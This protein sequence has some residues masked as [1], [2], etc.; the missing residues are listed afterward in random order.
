MS[1]AVSNN[2]SGENA[3]LDYELCVLSIASGTL[4]MSRGFTER[5][6]TDRDPNRTGWLQGRIPYCVQPE[7]VDAYKAML[8]DIRGE[9][10]Q[11]NAVIGLRAKGS[12]D[13]V[14]VRI[15]WKKTYN[16]QGEAID[17]VGVVEPLHA[18]S[19]KLSRSEREELERLRSNEEIQ[20]RYIQNLMKYQEQLR[21]Y[22][23]DRKNNIIAVSAL[24][25]NGDL[26]GAKRYINEISIGLINKSSIINTGN[27]AIDALLS[28]K[29][30]EAGENGIRVDHMVGLS[31]GLKI[32]MRDLC[33]AVGCALDNA[34]EACRKAKETHDDPS[35]ILRL[36]EKQGVITFYM[37]NTSATPAQP[38]K[39]LLRTSK[40]DQLEHG[41]GL[42]NIA[43]VVRKYNGYFD[44]MPE[45]GKFTTKFTLFPE[46]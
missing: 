19:N 40:E 6:Q 41:F 14:A 12:Q 4:S 7:T 16:N 36:I 3:A 8:D 38:G 42:K 21:R 27:A 29:I 35:I 13:Y 2:V 43:T 17:A 46:M 45:E 33:L 44:V 23:H 26:E 24:I 28:E 15:K 1:G 34:I 32:E 9:K 18:S 11:G 37:E 39:L 31:M 20:A 5:Y 30:Q 22:R 10:D 25:D